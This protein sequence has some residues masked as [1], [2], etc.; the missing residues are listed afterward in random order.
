[1]VLSH[2]AYTTCTSS[3]EHS[4]VVG[5]TP[6]DTSSIFHQPG[7]APYKTQPDAHLSLRWCQIWKKLS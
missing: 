7:F 6:S 1:M 3:K 2:K 5:G 4:K